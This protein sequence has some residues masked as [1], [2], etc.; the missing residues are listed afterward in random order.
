MGTGFFDTSHETF[1]REYLFKKYKPT[2]Y[3]N[4]SH[5]FIGTFICNI[6][7]TQ[8]TLRRNCFIW[9]MSMLLR[10]GAPHHTRA[11]AH[12]MQSHHKEGEWGQGNNLFSDHLS[13]E[14]CSN[15]L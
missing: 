10:K 15:V 2:W 4:A 14:R 7:N 5:M 12:K 9:T 6:C 1:T 13:K 11:H 3:K 8:F